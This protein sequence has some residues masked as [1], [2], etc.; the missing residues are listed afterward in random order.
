MKAA[1]EDELADT[2]SPD[3]AV[4][5]AA[6]LQECCRRLREQIRA[7]S[8]KADRECQAADTKQGPQSLP[9]YRCRGASTPAAIPRRSASGAA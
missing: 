8:E 3:P 5:L 9:G 1:S 7:I 4:L 6:D 2:S